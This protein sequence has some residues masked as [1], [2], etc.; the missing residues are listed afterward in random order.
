MALEYLAMKRQDL[1]K[2]PPVAFGSARL[3]GQ[4]STA[5]TAVTP[6]S[7]LVVFVNENV[8]NMDVYDK[9]LKPIHLESGWA[10][11]LLIPIRVPRGQT[12]NDVI[13]GYKLS[14][15]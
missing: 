15:E 3:N 13:K 10:D 14:D 12:F 11:V 5:F 4:P 2:L 9:H 8:M 7:K 6:G 1:P